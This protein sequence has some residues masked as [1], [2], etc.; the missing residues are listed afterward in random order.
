MIIA[1]QSRQKCYTDNQI[2]ELQFKLREQSPFEG[3]PYEERNE[4]L[5]EGKLSPHYIEPFKITKRVGLVAYYV[6]LPL[7]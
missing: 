1:A 4:I 6:A 3:I 5:E 2:Q 7:D